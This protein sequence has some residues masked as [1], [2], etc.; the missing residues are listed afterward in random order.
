MFRQP[1]QPEAAWCVDKAGIKNFKEDFDYSG[2]L[3]DRYPEG[4]QG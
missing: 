4:T 3:T 1:G 2:K